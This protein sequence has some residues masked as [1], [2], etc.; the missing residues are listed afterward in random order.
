MH[1]ADLALREGVLQ[2]ADFACSVVGRA[3]RLRDRLRRV[4][5]VYPDKSPFRAV[6][7]LSVRRAVANGFESRDIFCRRRPVD[8]AAPLGPLADQRLACDCSPARR[9]DVGRCIRSALRS[10][11]TMER[12]AA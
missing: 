5:A 4:L 1:L 12:T 9:A 6:W 3:T 8:A 10:D 11:A 7:H 2:L